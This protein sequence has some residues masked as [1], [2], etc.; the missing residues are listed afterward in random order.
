MIEQGSL[1]WHKQRLGYFTSSE[2]GKLL[3]KSTKFKGEVFGETAKKYI[4][5]VAAEREIDER[6]LDIE[7]G[8]FEMYLKRVES[9]SKYMQWGKDIEDMARSAYAEEKGYEVEEV[10]FLECNNYYG[11]SSDGICKKDGIIVGCLEIKCPLPETHK[12][13]R[14]IQNA[15]DLKIANQTYYAQCQ[16]HCVAWGVDWCDF[17]SYDPMCKVPIHIVNIPRSNDSIKE[18]TER[19]ELANKFI[20]SLK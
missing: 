12:A 1:Q 3:V 2:V 7:S 8:A 4:L 16:M 17:V 14:Q 5:S 6:F 9:H 20:E 19:I 10:G 11:D 18:I 13:Y 15:N